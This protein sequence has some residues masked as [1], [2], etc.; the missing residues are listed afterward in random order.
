MQKE[1]CIFCK[2]ANGE[3]PTTLVYETDKLAAFNDANPKM[4]IHVLIVP[5][6]HYASLSDDIP[7]ELLG[8]LMKAVPEVAKATGIY[9]SGYR[10]VIN[11]GDDANQTVKHVHV[12]VIGGAQMQ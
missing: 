3:I 5:K 6:D 8:A 9:E 10:V 11:T 12:H 1:D 7:A 4:P 2:L